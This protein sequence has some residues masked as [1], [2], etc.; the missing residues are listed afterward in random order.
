MASDN[1]A[2][3]APNGDHRTRILKFLPPPE[4]EKKETSSQSHEAMNYYC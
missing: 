1:I 3:P 2:G 4:P